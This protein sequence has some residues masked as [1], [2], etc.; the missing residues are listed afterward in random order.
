MWWNRGPLGKHFRIC[1]SNRNK[2]LKMDAF[3]WSNYYCPHMKKFLA[4]STCSS[5]NLHSTMYTFYCIKYSNVECMYQKNI[6]KKLRVYIA[7]G[8]TCFK[9]GY[10]TK[11]ASF[12]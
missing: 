11:I 8:Y 7:E 5:L 4:K 6:Y 2:D 12:I 10:Q 9:T 1:Q 3:E